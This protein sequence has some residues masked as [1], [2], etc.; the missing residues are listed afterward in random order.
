MPIKN[1]NKFPKSIIYKWIN[2]YNYYF[3]NTK[4]LI[5][6]TYNKI[7]KKYKHLYER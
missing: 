7:T 2:N 3:E 6:T 4:Q 1:I 5:I